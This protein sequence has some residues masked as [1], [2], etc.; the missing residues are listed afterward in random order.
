MD[1][2]EEMRGLLEV[3]SEM[4]ADEAAAWIARIRAAGGRCESCESRNPALQMAATG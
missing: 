2:Q 3:L 1:Q 4:S